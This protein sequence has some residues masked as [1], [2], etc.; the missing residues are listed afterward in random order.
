MIR[1][2][3]APSITLP[4]LY[5]SIDLTDAVQA[6]LLVLGLAWLAEHIL[7]L[8][9]LRKAFGD[10]RYAWAAHLLTAFIALRA[11]E[12]AGFRWLSLPMGVLFIAAL[13]I[14]YIAASSS[15]EK[16]ELEAVLSV[17]SSELPGSV[18]I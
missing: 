8:L 4:A 10:R 13:I 14:A 6:I 11:L 9:D 1:E 17:A 16:L 3:A 2:Q 12:A 15:L 18:Y 7:M 5:T